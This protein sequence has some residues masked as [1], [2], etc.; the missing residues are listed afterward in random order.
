MISSPKAELEKALTVREA[1]KGLIHIEGDDRLIFVAGQ[2][3]RLNLPGGGID[4]GETLDAALYREIDEELGIKPNQLVN[5]QPAFIT[6]GETTSRHGTRGISRW[7]VYTAGI[8]VPSN[9]IFRPLDND[10][11]LTVEILRPDDFLRCKNIS[12]IAEKAVREFMYQRR[13]H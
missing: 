11:D 5:V 12:R 4:Y 13:M 1:A 7:L 3:G 8:R 6:S 2:S 9:Y 10:E